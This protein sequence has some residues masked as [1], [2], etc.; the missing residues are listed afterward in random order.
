MLRRW[1]MLGA[2]AASVWAGTCIALAESSAGEEAAVRQVV[3]DVI[4]ALNNGDIQS[5][6]SHFADDAVI[7]SKAAGRKARKDEY[8]RALTN[9]LATREIIRVEHRQLSVGIEGPAHA[10][11]RATLDYTL[12]SSPGVSFRY[13]WKLQKRDGRWSIV[14][15]NYQ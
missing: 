2:F 8:A 7:D 5:L 14:E 12:R 4:A 10:H 6:L 13:E 11:A 3:S 15:T 1:I 9:A